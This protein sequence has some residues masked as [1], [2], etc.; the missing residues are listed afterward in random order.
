[1]IRGFYCLVLLLV[2]HSSYAEQTSEEFGDWVLHCETADSKNC[3]MSQIAKW[4][5]TG[6]TLSRLNL[7]LESPSYA[8]VLLPLGTS[9][10]DLPELYIGGSLVTKLKPKQCLADGCY[11]RYPLKTGQIEQFLR[12]FSGSVKIVAGNG[13]ELEIP[14]SGTGTRAAHNRY[15]ER[16]N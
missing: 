3:V 15:K 7:H 14:I 8:E 16:L 4:E 10:E 9:L 1:M 11:F 2:A 6:E 12:M 5:N 13:E